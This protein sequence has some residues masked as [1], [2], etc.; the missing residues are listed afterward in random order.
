M[1]F[2]CIKYWSK[3]YNNH[4]I[5]DHNHE[6]W[7]VESYLIFIFSYFLSVKGSPRFTS[8]CLGSW[9][10]VTG[11]GFHPTTSSS[12]TSQTVRT[13]TS[14]SGRIYF[15][16]SYLYISTC[17]LGWI[18]TSCV[19]FLSRYYFPGWYNSSTS[20]H[21][22]RY[23][24]SKGMEAPVIDDCVMAYLFSQVGAVTFLHYYIVIE[25]WVKTRNA[26]SSS[27]VFSFS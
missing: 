5:A 15:L 3:S 8:T 19:L 10:K 22:H 7:L 11:R 18:I 13:F 27:R 24:V 2:Y 6:S 17:S 26:G 16:T 12:S 4:C 21:A 14:E 1:L 25:L 9:G 23:G 20:F